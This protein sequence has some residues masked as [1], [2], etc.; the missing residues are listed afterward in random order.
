MANSANS[1]EPMLPW[2]APA[3]P[4]IDAPVESGRVD[5][6]LAQIA[7]LEQEV[8]QGR[9]LF[10]QERLRHATQIANLRLET[11]TELDVLRR[12]ELTRT[13]NVHE[14]YRALLNER[15]LEYEHGLTTASAEAAARLESEQQRH[16]EMLKQERSRRQQQDDAEYRRSVTE[17]VEQHD[18]STQDL[19]NELVQAASSISRLEAAL[20]ETTEWAKTAESK[21]GDLAM[22][23][24]AAER[25]LEQVTGAADQRHD[26]QHAEL[27]QRA[28]LAEQRLTDERRRAAA[29]LAEVLEQSA[30]LAAETDSLRSSLSA[31][32][33]RSSQRTNEEIEQVRNDFEELS[34]AAQRDFGA[35]RW[36]LEQAAAIAKQESDEAYRALSIAADEQTAVFLQRESEL[37]ALIAELRRHV[38]AASGA[39]RR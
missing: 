33:E 16:E 15:Q 28:D 30:A 6:L 27:E 5:D 19:Q 24:S 32:A 35:E 39:E 13:Q 29:T 1:N 25:R 10:E 31:A 20:T 22:R 18:R 3:L 9:E 17:L 12:E 23:L 2:L 21:R 14:S 4:K 34:E 11:D 38:A 7:Y 26:A 8:L 36:R 37:E